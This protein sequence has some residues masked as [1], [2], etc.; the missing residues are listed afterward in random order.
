MTDTPAESRA[1]PH[2][3]LQAY[4]ACH[5]LTLAVY[6]VSRSWLRPDGSSASIAEE[7]RGAVRAATL[8]I[9]EGVGLSPRI[10]RRRLD[11]SCG[12]L[13]RLSAVLTLARDVGLLSAGQLT[14]LEI[15]RDHAARLTRGLFLSVKSVRRKE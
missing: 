14:E 9:V 1:Q 12:K 2:E 4:V 13:S 10:F 7:A 11:E 15:R 8:G 5:E 6:Q 3:R